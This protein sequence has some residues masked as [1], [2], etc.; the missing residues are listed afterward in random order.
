MSRQP[1][2]ALQPLHEQQ[3]ISSLESAYIRV[4]GIDEVGRG[5]WAGPVAVGAFVYELNQPVTAGVNDSKKLSELKRNSISAELKQFP[6]QILYA[7]A[8]IVDKLGIAKAIEELIAQQISTFQDDRTYFLVDGQFSRRFGER[9]KTVIKGDAT[10]YS[11]AAAA[12]LTK[13]ARDQL[14]CDLDIQYPGYAFAA[15]K[16]YGTVQ[17]QTQLELLGPSPIHR[18][19]YA[20]IANLARKP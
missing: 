6:H 18:F 4:V 5:C 7:E 14:M 8:S 17:H 9:V 11:I 19:S 1:Q 13:V 12:I 3:I 15:H 2:I 16:G 20:P 10:Y